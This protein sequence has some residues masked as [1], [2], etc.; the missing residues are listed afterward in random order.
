MPTASTKRKLE[1]LGCRLMKSFMKKEERQETFASYQIKGKNSL[2]T[3]WKVINEKC[4][5]C[6]FQV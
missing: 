1:N 5:R 3:F 6:V 4:K 2:F